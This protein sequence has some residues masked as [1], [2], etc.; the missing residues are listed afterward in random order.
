MSITMLRVTVVP[1][2]E[3]LLNLSFLKNHLLLLRAF[4][5]F[6]RGGESKRGASAVLPRCPPARA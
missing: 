3:S 2:L 6:Q 5:H 1:Q 4:E